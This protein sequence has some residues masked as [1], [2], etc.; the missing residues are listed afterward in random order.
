MEAK[1]SE[2]LGNIATGDEEEYAPIEREETVKVDAVRAA[3]FADKVSSAKED[4]AANPVE[5]EAVTS[6]NSGESDTVPFTANGGLND[7]LSGSKIQLGEI[8]EEF[9][10]EKWLEGGQ[11]AIDLNKKAVNS[12][13]TDAFFS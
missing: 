9:G 2:V 6:V 5:K 1:E 7:N 4:I 3:S 12:P 11:A 13:S 8:K 10:K